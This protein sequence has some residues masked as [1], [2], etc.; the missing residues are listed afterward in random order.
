ME[1]SRPVVRVTEIGEYIRYRSCERRFKLGFN[2]RSLA[3]QLPFAERL[4]NSIDP[5]LDAHGRQRENEWEDTLRAADLVTV[6]RRSPQPGEPDG[7]PVEEHD[8]WDVFVEQVQALSIGQPAYGREVKVAA[9]LGAFRVEGRIDFMLLLWNGDGSPKLR[10]VECKAS[11]KDRTYQRVQVTLYLMIVREMM[12][13]RPLHI[14]GMMVSPDNIECVVARIDETTNESQ[15]ILALEPLDTEREE[16]DLERLLSSD[17]PLLRIVQ[18]ELDAIDYQLDQK[19][20]DC[21]FAVHCYPESAR[22]RRLE[23]LSIEPSVARIMRGAG[24]FTIDDLAELDLTGAQAAQVRAEPSFTEN[25]GF[26]RQKARARRRTLPDGDVDPD[27]YEVEALRNTG[28]GQLPL[29]E[30]DGRR[31]IR[32]YLSVS[33]D[34]VENRVGALAAHVTRSQG[35]LHTGFIETDDGWRPDP[36]VVE[37]IREDG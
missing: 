9:D 30:R 28:Q 34:Y 19:C 15:E 11:R 21:I 29:H 3:K 32:I 10:L 5:V 36:Q 22:Q 35:Q 26:L 12:R 27:S 17:G 24:I 37:R 6:T 20:D 25:L 18:S 31:L 13:D 8:D 23:L 14:G 16:A 4:F 7:S 2:N 33:Y 1:T